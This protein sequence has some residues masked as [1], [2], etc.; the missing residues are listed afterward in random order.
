M[1]T[2]YVNGSFYSGQEATVSVYDHGLLYGDGLFEGISVYK[3]RIFKLKEH[4]LRLFEGAQA[5]MIKIPLTLEELGQA[6]VETLSK[7]KLDRG[8]IR[9]VLTR[10]I[11]DLGLD[12]DKCEKPTLIIIAD[13]ISLYPDHIYE[14][15]ISLITSA[16]RRITPDQWDPRIK[17]LNYMNNIMAKIEAKQAG[18]MEALMLNQ[19][20]Y[21][22]ECTADNIFIYKDKTLLTPASYLGLLEGITRNTIMDL[23]DAAEITVKETNLTRFDIYTAEECFLTGSGAEMLPVIQLDGRVIGKGIPGPIYSKMYQAFLDLI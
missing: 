18:C 11:G 13:T 8:Y 4:L 15:G 14:K 10:G 23:A 2:V 7:E 16:T 9:V 17:S 20:G 1:A 3:G 19:Q 6:V 21:V 22:T 12:P 5:L